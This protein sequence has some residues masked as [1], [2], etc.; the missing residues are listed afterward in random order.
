MQ[1][2][3]TIFRDCRE[4]LDCGGTLIWPRPPA[5]GEMRTAEQNGKSTTVAA[6]ASYTPRCRV[7]LWSVSA[8]VGALRCFCHSLPAVDGAAELSAE[9]ER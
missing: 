1:A 9:G 2:A 4:A 5:A 3:G 8:A 6:M 7:S